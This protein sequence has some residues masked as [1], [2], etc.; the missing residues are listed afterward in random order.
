MDGDFLSRLRERLPKRLPEIDLRWLKWLGLAAGALVLV[1]A[2]GAGT[3]YYLVRD[4]T[5]ELPLKADLYALNRPAAFAFTDEKGALIG[6]RGAMVGE[7]LKLADMPAYL[8]A[9]FLAMEDR[10]FREHRG[11]DVR[12]LARATL[13]NLRA[14]GIVQGGSTVTQQLMKV[15]FLNPERT[16]KRKLEE[17]AGALELEKHLTKDEILELYLNRIYLG[18]GAYGVDGAARVYFGKSARAVTLAEAAMLAS[19]TRAPSVFSPRRDL[20]A[21]QAR[22]G[23]V[24]AA[25]VETGAIDAKAADEAR[26]HPAI[27]AD[28]ARDLARNYFLDVAAEEAKNLAKGWTGDLVVV[29]TLDAKMQDQARNAVV[30]L[31]ESDGAKS[32]A[33]Q[34]AL[35]AMETSGAVRALV[36]GRDYAESAFNRATQAHRQ[37]GSAFKPFVY[38]AALE[39]GMT[40]ATRRYDEPIEIE[41]YSPDNFGH[42]HWGLVSLK[43]ALA[44]SINTVAVAL[45]QEVG[46]E[47]VIA[48]ARRLGVA[49]PLAP[50]RSLA[51]GTSEMTLYELT[52]A[53][54]SFA[55]EGRRVVPYTVVEVRS[56]AGAV[57]FKRDTQAA[58]GVVDDREVQAMNAMLFEAVE[59]GTGRAARIAGREIAG[60]TGT[61]QEFRDAWFVGYVP[62]FIAGVWVGNDDSAP[63]KG[64]TGGRIPARIWK[65]F[66]TAALEGKPVQAL[67]REE[68][69]APFDLDAYYASYGYQGAKPEA[70]ESEPAWEQRVREA[71]NSRADRRARRDASRRRGL[72]DWLFGDDT[73]DDDPPP[74]PLRRRDGKWTSVPDRQDDRDRD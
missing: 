46:L 29:T 72:L 7:R 12:G 34:G 61:S 16:F 66:M 35:V 14:G 64:V 3:L 67:P 62:G 6:H 30:K 42:A 9:A 53:Y 71:S 33:G 51:L 10:R 21:A 2:L 11:V 17:L 39:Q 44:N 52:A 59:G 37:P 48:V 22:A 56:P 18:S 49:S 36:G 4:A 25:M 47:S 70:D 74:R 50:N 32:A 26:A 27:V 69:P 45:G 63:T 19:L 1:A 24:L 40:P 55:A 57:I 20:P 31:L 43:E 5:P 54:G 41:G 15:L 23:L 73:R 58:D 68:P 8:P 65:N 60:K 28:R 13:A 38:L